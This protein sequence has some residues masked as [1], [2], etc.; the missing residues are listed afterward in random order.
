MALHQLVLPGMVVNVGEYFNEVV[1]LSRGTV[2]KKSHG[3]TE[4][5]K[6]VNLGLDSL[7]T[8][9]QQLSTNRWI[10]VKGK[11][12]TWLQRINNGEIVE[13]SSL[14]SPTDKPKEIR[15]VNG[16]HRLLAL[17]KLGATRCIVMVPE[18]QVALFQTTFP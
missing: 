15:A 6:A 8:H 10:E 17:Q 5:W 18:S 3:D 1:E 7:I 2:G 4:D 12:N 14:W 9:L 11:T 16:R 13:A